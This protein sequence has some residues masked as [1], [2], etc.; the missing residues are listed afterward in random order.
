[1]S[2]E[3]WSVGE[4][5]NKCRRKRKEKETNVSCVGGSAGAFIGVMR[6]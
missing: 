2:A 6:G 5:E 3:M 4:D 1:M